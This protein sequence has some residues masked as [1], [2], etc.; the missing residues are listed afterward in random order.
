VAH[1]A[2]AAHIGCA[3]SALDIIVALYYRVMKKND[4]FVLS[5]GHGA[6]A[7]Y[8]VLEN[9]GL[10]PK[11]HLDHFFEDGSI[12]PSHPILK[13]EYGI[14]ATTGSLGHGLPQS[15]GMALANKIDKNHESVYA[16]I[17]DGECDEGSNWEAFLFAAHH[18]LDNLTVIID[19][20]K[21]QCFGK[22]NEVMNLEPLAEKFKAFNWQVREV[23]GHDFSQILAALENCGQ[24]GKPAV[25]IA[26]TVKGKGVNFMENTNEWHSNKLTIEYLEIALKQL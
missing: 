12:L 22:T 16:V 20:N 13:P 6:L 1:K 15:V 11:E 14:S 5:K 10:L 8:G 23:D 9:K 4:I 2:E 19:Y 25:I 24:D 3:L 26:H 7:L 17:G 21:L 18:R